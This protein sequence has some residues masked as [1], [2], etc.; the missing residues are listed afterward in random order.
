M[1][2]R[3]NLPTAA[4]PAPLLVVFQRGGKHLGGGHAVATDATPTSCL[5]PRLPPRVQEKPLDVLVTLPLSPSSLS[6]PTRNPL[7]TREPPPLAVMRTRSQHRRQAQRACPSCAASTTTSI[8]RRWPSNRARRRRQ[9]PQELAG[10]ASRRLQLLR[11]QKLPD[12]AAASI[13]SAV[14]FCFFS[15][16]SWSPRTSSR[17]L[18]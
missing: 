18:P 7:L 5:L 9:L 6:H 10:P 4:Q 1:G 3:P 15:P 11:P 16:I 13:T 14:S 12:H 8:W 2:P 17:V